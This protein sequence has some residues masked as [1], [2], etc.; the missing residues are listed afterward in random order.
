MKIPKTCSLPILCDKSFLVARPDGETLKVSPIIPAT[1]NLMLV[2]TTG[3][4]TEKGDLEAQCSMEFNGI[5]DN[6]YRSY[7]ARSTPE[8]RRQFFESAIK[9][10][11]AG[12]T[13]SDWPDSSGRHDGYHQAA[14]G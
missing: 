6:I 14:G 11:V 7:F 8:Q 10:I 12:A 3:K 5:N 2:K 1:E 13:L 4:I 9:G